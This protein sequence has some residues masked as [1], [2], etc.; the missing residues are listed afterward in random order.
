MNLFEEKHNCGF[1]TEKDLEGVG[2]LTM[3]VGRNSYIGKIRLK[4]GKHD[5]NKGHYILIIEYEDAVNYQS[6]KNIY[7]KDI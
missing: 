4:G 3:T 7:M 6:Y 1:L 2:W 5:V